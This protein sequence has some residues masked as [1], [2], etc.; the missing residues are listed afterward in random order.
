MWDG[1]YPVWSLERFRR[2]VGGGP[3]YY[4]FTCMPF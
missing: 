1:R 2:H 3:T 4:A